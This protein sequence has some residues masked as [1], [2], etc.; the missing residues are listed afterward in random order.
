MMLFFMATGNCLVSDR[1]R[2]EPIACRQRHNHALFADLLLPLHL[3][4]AVT[5]Q[6]LFLTY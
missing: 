1:Y 5:A 2:Y 6:H 4:Y 3:G